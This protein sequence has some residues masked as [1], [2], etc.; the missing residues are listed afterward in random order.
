MLLNIIGYIGLGFLGIIALMMILII[1]KRVY[2]QFYLSFVSLILTASF[3]YMICCKANYL[4]S[5]LALF[6][7]YAS[8]WI[9][10]LFACLRLGFIN[11]RNHFN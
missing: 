9:I 10:A 7:A 1:R 6:C 3:I 11:S 2:V 5:W 4:Y 8:S